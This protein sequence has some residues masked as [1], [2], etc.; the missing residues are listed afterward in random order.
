M[1]ARARAADN[2]VTMC[3]AVRNCVIADGAAAAAAADQRCKLLLRS[4]AAQH[5]TR[6]SHNNSYADFARAGRQ[7]HRCHH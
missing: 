4:R 5:T 2:N 1:R 3:A 7:S 6:D